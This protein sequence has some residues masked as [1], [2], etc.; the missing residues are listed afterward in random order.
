L[1]EEL[2]KFYLAGETGFK[3]EVKNLIRL[4]TGMPGNFGI[5]HTIYHLKYFCEIV[6]RAIAKSHETV[7]IGFYAYRN[8]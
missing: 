4:R 3:V 2:G 1:R 7:N 5:P 6:K 8:S